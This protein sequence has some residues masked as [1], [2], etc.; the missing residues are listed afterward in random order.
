MPETKQTASEELAQQAA[1]TQYLVQ[2]KV[3]AYELED[4]TNPDSLTEIE[5]WVELGRYEV[6]SGSRRKAIEL[7]MQDHHI[8]G[9]TFHTIPESSAATET[10]RAKM[11]I[12]WE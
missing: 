3:K 12:S 6:P 7:A 2:L 4:D 1:V 5:A 10:C 9:G 11:S 8:D